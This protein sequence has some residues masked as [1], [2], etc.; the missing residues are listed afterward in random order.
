MIE[1]RGR[2]RVAG[3][4][5]DFRAAPQKEASNLSREAAYFLG[6]SRTI[7]DMG[8]VGKIKQSFGRKIVAKMGEDGQTT[9]TRIKYAYRPVG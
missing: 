9:H 3:H 7:G 4:N 5:D 6:R 8:L 2:R 1:G